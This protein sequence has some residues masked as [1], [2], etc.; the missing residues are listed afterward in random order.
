MPEVLTKIVTLREVN[1]PEHTQLVFAGVPL[2]LRD[3]DFR[4]YCV[5]ESFYRAR[6]LVETAE[7]ARLVVG[8]QFSI[9]ASTVRD[10]LE[11]R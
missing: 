4:D 11:W 3:K 10:I 7:E 8:L 2:P 6:K 1:L 9:S 5:R